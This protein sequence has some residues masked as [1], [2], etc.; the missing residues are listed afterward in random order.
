MVEDQVDVC[1]CDVRTEDGRVF[2]RN[3]R[4]LNKSPQLPV[5]VPPRM[6]VSVIPRE[7]LIQPTEIV[8]VELPAEP[9][10]IQDKV[11]EVPPSPALVQ[12]T[13][14]RASGRQ[15]KTPAHFKDFDM[16]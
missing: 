2:P 11:T 6:E 16:S 14:V 3:R 15:I 4:H 1:S 7:P 13:G 8:P 12:P 9:P 10:L 5:A